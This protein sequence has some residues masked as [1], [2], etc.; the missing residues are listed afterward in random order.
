[1][2]LHDHCSIWVLYPRVLIPAT[3]KVI[4]PLPYWIYRQKTELFLISELHKIKNSFSPFRQRAGNFQVSTIWANALHWHMQINFVYQK[5]ELQGNISYL[6][7]KK[8]IMIMEHQQI[9]VRNTTSESRCC[10]NVNARSENRRRKRNVVTL[11]FGRSNDV[12]NTTLWQ[13]Y[14]TSLPKCKQ[15]LTLQ[16][17]VPAGN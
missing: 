7:K 5:M 15:N 11:V 6:W 12:G 2:I 17:S 13:R 1:M 4:K 8:V 3:E 9:F 16:R 14:P 10:C